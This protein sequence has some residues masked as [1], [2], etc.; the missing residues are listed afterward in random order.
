LRENNWEDKLGKIKEE[1]DKEIEENRLAE[2][3]LRE[4]Y[5]DEKPMIIEV[6]R[7]EL[8]IVVKGIKQPS[9][10]CY[11]QPNLEVAGWGA[12]LK[13]PIV[14]VGATVNIG[15]TFSFQF[16]DNGYYLKVIKGTYDAKTQKPYEI[17]ADIPPP[18]TVE[19]IQ[20]QVTEFL[21]A[22]RDTIKRARAGVT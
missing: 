12:S 22:R 14:G 5:K 10:K 17:N 15:I 19:A 2:R 7:S 3:Q 16:S 21:E 9:K 18:V 8:G 20:K 13:V 11:D 6:L 1:T 4:K